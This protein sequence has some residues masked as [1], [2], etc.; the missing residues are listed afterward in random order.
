MS[1]NLFFTII[2]VFLILVNVFQLVGNY[3]E[4]LPHKPSIHQE[5]GGYVLRQLHFDRKQADQYKTLIDDHKIR[6]G[7]LKS[8]LYQQ[9]KDLYSS[10]GKE[11]FPPSTLDSLQAGICRLHQAINK[12]NLSHFADVKALC[13][14]DQQQYFSSF[15]DE[16]LVRLGPEKK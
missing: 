13:R 12:E 7:H 6:L 3:Y 1:K 14:P 15:L 8:N 5:G 9:Y 11:N 4:W 2:I 10:V 16:M